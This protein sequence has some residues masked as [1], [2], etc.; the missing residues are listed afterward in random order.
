MLRYV[1]L[2]VLFH[3]VAVF[4][5]W[6][7]SPKEVYKQV[8]PAVVL[9]LGS[10]GGKMGSGGTGSIVDARGQVVTNAHVVISDATGRPY[11][12][13]Y[14]YLKPSKLTGD[15]QKD[16]SQRYVA[17][18]VA[19]SAKEDLDIALL[20]IEGVSG[21]LPVVALGDSEDVEMG[22]EVVA[23]GHPE[24]GGL[25]TLTTGSVS[26]VIQNYGRVQ[27][28]HVF[29]TEASFNRGNSGGP[30]LDSHG[31]M[32]GVNTMI[33]RKASDGVAITDVNFSLK[34]RVVTAWLAGRGVSLAFGK[35]VSVQ[36]VP[37]PA[38]AVAQPVSPP[39]TEQKPAVQ[40]GVPVEKPV[41]QEPPK[42]AW[43]VTPS[44]PKAEESVKGKKVEVSKI[45][46]RIVTPK[47][48]F[49]MDALRYA[50]MRELEQMM[51]EM[52]GK[53]K[54]TPQGAGRNMGLW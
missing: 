35:D 50:Q 26:S 9:V 5:A 13:L 40:V 29:Q 7:L 21:P 11:N 14:V 41:Q 36:P 51:D 8:S 52:R 6:G 42:V 12:T 3:T 4:P 28:K 49:N 1:L 10:D 32:I 18:V 44:L 30:L 24:Q 43:V 25:W 39:K 16:L 15:S 27:G 38:V 20:Q 47:R 53:V 46:P 17:R 54:K 2:G 34:S 19:Y 48:P 37:S 33:A 23:I 22:E 31:R 45:K